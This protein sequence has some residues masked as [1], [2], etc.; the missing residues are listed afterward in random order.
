MELLEFRSG[1]QARLQRIS[2]GEFYEHAV[3]QLRPQTTQKVTIKS[4]I[5]RNCLSDAVMVSFYRAS[6]SCN[7]VV[8][9]V[10]LTHAENQ[11]CRVNLDPRIGREEPRQERDSCAELVRAATPSDKISGA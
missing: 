6:E 2:S 10:V 3:Q 7:R 11:V 8:A 1:D 9:R 5:E 4:S